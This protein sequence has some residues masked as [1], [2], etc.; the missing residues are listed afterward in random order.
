MTAPSTR[1]PLHPQPEPLESLSSWLGRLAGLYRMPVKQLLAA[2]VPDHPSHLIERDW[3]EVPEPLAKAL[4]E[5]AGVDPGHLKTM[6]LGGWTPWLL[7]K[8]SVRDFEAQEVFDT[9]VRQ[10][11]VL[12]RPGEAGRNHVTASRHWRGPGC[13]A[14]P[15]GSG[16]AR[17]ASPTRP[18]PARWHGNCR[19]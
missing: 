7:D 5:R 9:Y 3:W 6:T 8:S 16:T 10:N 11:S 19:W 17:S 14:P 18:G 2:L 12:L 13:R 4:V 1:W 15:T